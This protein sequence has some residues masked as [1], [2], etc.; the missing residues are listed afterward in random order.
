MVTLGKE[1]ELARGVGEERRGRVPQ[2][3]GQG[4]SPPGPPHPNTRLP[5]S[6]VVQPSTLT[7]IGDSSITL[8]MQTSSHSHSESC[9]L[10]GC[11]HHTHALLCC[12][13]CCLGCAV[14]PP[15]DESEWGVR[16]PGAHASCCRR[17][18]ASGWSKLPVFTEGMYVNLSLHQ[19]CLRLPARSKQPPPPP[20]LQAKIR[21]V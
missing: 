9:F 6:L 21:V 7:T 11:C 10:F 20:Q 14:M 17:R 5:P 1:E 12:C 4:V 18:P 3:P 13:C 8:P 2:D 16:Q 15:T 19:V